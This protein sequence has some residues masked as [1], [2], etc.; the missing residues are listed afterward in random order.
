MK[1]NKTFLGIIG[2]LLAA[3]LMTLVCSEGVKVKG[4]PLFA[5]CSVLIFV[6]QWLCFLPSWLFHTERFFD[7]TGSITYLTVIAVSLSSTPSLDTR[8]VL[9]GVFIGLWALRLGTFLFFRVLKTGEDRRFEL[10]KHQFARF[11]MTWTLQGLWVLF[12]ISAALAAITTSSQK[13]LSWVGILGIL[14]WLIGFTF[15][16]IADNQKTKFR[17]VLNN[18]EQFISQGLWSWSQHPN[19]FGEILIWIG[20]AIVAL[21]ALSGWLYVT[22]VSPVFVWLLLTRISGIPM[23]D[24]AAEKRWGDNPNYQIWR[25]S[26]PKLVPRLPR[27]HST[28]F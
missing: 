25:D 14:I 20:I 19:Y 1:K 10:I 27:K 4:I 24:Q 5:I 21:P 11:L 23:L 8:S 3:S 22:L 9:L 15:E 7:L 2:S 17:K 12:T 6:I 13:P 18:R 28:R 26:T 16:I